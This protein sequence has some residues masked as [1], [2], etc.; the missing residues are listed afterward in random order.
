LDQGQRVLAYKVPTF[1]DVVDG[2]VRLKRDPYQITKDVSERKLRE[3]RDRFNDEYDASNLLRLSVNSAYSISVPMMRGVLARW[4]KDGFRPDVVICDYP[5]I[6][7]GPLK[8][9]MD[10]REQT[11]ATWMMF[12]KM[13]QDLHCLV[14]VVTQAD[15]NSYDVDL[16]TRD[17]FTDD[18]RK[19]DHVT[20]MFG[21]NQMTKEKEQGLYRLNWLDRRGEYY[22]ER[23]CCYCAGCL[24]IAQPFMLSWFR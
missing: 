5:D 19:H 3:Y 13:R 4:E 17:H 20:A 12:S 8:G 15:A 7:L 2:E 18:R 11:N 16:L 24:E 21:L 14:I 22:S 6:L 1:L 10:K 23:E 9:T